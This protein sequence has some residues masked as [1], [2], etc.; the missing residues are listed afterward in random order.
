MN[1]RQDGL[2][3]DLMLFRRVCK[4]WKIKPNLDLFA[5]GENKQCKKFIN[6]NLALGVTW[7]NALT[8][9]IQLLVGEVHGCMEDNTISGKW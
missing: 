7:V 8:I 9:P 5:T 4:K 2:Q 6:Y 1:T 3:A